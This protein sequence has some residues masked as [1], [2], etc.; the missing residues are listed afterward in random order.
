MP[1]GAECKR[2]FINFVFWYE[3]AIG[4]EEF[5]EGVAMLTFREG[6]A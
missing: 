6:R 2:E 1:D 4:I 3:F 5:L